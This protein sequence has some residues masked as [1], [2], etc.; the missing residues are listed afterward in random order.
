MVEI[1]ETG[2]LLHIIDHCVR[3]EETVNG[4]NRTEFDNDKDIKDVVCFNIFQIGELAK[5]LSPS[6]ILE[7]SGVPWDKIKGMRDRIGHGYGTINW[8]NVWNTAT[9]DIK[10]LREYCE[11]VLN[12]NK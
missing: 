12:K 2:I 1:K 4:I 9:N 10:P 7:Y 3:V 11:K 5:H 8:D 6:F